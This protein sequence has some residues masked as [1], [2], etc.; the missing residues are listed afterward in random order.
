M[1]EPEFNNNSQMIFRQN[2]QPMIRNKHVLVMMPSVTTGYTAK[3]AEEAIGYYGGAVAGIAAIYR[4][5]AQVAG[6][7]V[8]SIY[9]VSDLPDYQSYESKDCPFCKK[10]RKIDPLVNSFGYSV[11]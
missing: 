10:G 9:S 6:H 2:I 7:P 1:L 4:A 8:R 11:L 3:R 5:V